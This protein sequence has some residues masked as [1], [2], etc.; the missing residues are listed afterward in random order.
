M[1]PGVFFRS[2]PVWAVI[3]CSLLWSGCDDDPAAPDV[4]ALAASVDVPPIIGRQDPIRVTF[5]EDVDPR[6][7][8]DPENFVVINQC[9]G[10]RI[11]GALALVDGRTIVFAPSSAINY[12]TPIS[13]RIQNVLTPAGNAMA[14]PFTFQVT[15]EA[16]PVADITWEF[17]TSPTNAEGS[18]V[19]FV[20]RNLGFF[21]TTP[22]ELYRTRN[23]GSSFE[24]R[25][26]SVNV[27]NTRNVRALSPDSVFMTASILVGGSFNTGAL[28]KSLDSGRTFVPAFTSNP[29]TF[30]S[31]ALR[32]RPALRPAALVTGGSPNLSVW[33]FDL[34]NDSAYKFGPVAGQFGTAGDLS[35]NDAN[36]VAV[37][38]QFTSATT[39]IGV[40]HTSATG[41]RSF[42]PVTL[43]AGT[44]LLRGAGFINNTDAFLL[45]DTSTVLRVNATTGAV[46]KL[47]AANGI[48]QTIIDP[49]A[50]S[51][52]AFSFT[53]ADFAPDRQ[54]GFIVGFLVRRAPGQ[55]D[56]RQGVLL[57]TRDGG[58]TFQRQAVQG[59]RD[60]GLGFEPIT[61]VQVLARDFAAVVGQNGIV[62]ARKQDTSAA[63][64]ACSFE[65]P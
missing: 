13:V 1:K 22:G 50:N 41:G 47:T 53:K 36:A 62:A 48:P 44:P 6:S 18:G 21:S 51:V 20:N 56:V 34:A 14:A 3:A 35:P 29:A 49:V 60:N 26:K 17:L 40:A 9:T 32:K 31:L 5:N 42:V 64:A 55:G 16:P 46:T 63:T 57:I 8:L 45:G 58:A 39:A 19:S 2:A 24:A 54:L 23:G 30:F 25:F 27:I 28:M 59:A 15:T 10:L 43:P 12:L 4:P 61:D 7:A 37:G 52:T 65:T 33:R 38:F 11:P